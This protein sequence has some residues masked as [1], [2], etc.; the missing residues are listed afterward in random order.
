MAT[1][2]GGLA[3]QLS[4]LSLFADVGAAELASVAHILDERRF[5]E[6]ERVIRQG[7]TGSAFYV[8]LGGEAAIRVNGKDYGKLGRGDFF[9]EISVLLGEPPVADIVAMREL[10]CAIIPG[11][12]LESFMLGHPKGMWRMLQSE[13]RKLRTATSWRG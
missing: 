8:I 10:H 3:D 5:A 4:S 2:A 7:V 6:G 9:G 13:A 12:A 11:P 1:T